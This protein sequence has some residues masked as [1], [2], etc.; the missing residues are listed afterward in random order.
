[1]A[2]DADLL[3]ELLVE[4]AELLLVKV[5]SITVSFLIVSPDSVNI[6][7]ILLSS[8]CTKIFI[9]KKSIHGFFP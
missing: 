2:A 3:V 1:M 5:L 6:M 8:G 9:E 4:L 7:S